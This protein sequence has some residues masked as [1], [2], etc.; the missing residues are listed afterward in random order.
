M[1]ADDT[2]LDG[3]TDLSVGDR[4]RL[5]RGRAGLTQEEAAGLA[6]V[7]VSLWRKWEQGVR[8]IPSF[9]RLV[10]VAQALGV[11]DLR[12]L[13]G[14]PLALTP[15]GQPRHEAVGPLRAAMARHPVLL[16]PAEMTDLD[17]LSRRVNA[18]W[19]A[20]QVASPWR[21]A[22]TG[23]VLPDLVVD[24]EAAL[25][26]GLDS[27]RAAR[28]AGAVY[29]L[30]RAWAKWVG[31]H[32]L[33][34]LAAERTLS[35]AERTDDASLVAAAGWNMA[36][37]LSTRGDAEEARMVAHDALAA[38]AGDFA[39]EQAP[40]ELVSAWGA[41]HLISMV[42]AVRLDDRSGARE[43]LR[44]AGRAA[45]R[46]GDDRND[47]WLAFGPTN[48][49]IHQVSYAVELGQSRT[50]LR[51]DRLLE[52]GRAPSVE[53]RVTHR[54]DVGAA[55]TRLREDVSAVRTLV[56]AERE[57]PEQLYYSPRARGVVRELLTRES[58]DTRGLLRPLASRLGV[59]A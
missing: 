52:V 53:R 24:V 56:D 50:A 54:M 33:A 9:S 42:A 55:H 58:A 31:E 27:R 5:W 16:P 57:S 2:R 20:A 41:L 59:L 21:Y 3:R 43:E 10:D 35:A 14:L 23:A 51:A 18:A 12:H 29:L 44:Q 22:H 37:A 25:R 4:I 45:A 30:A 13:T 47:W 39:T 15:G 49:A 34:M 32:D 7:S 48:V 40:A 28:L 17:R 11:D 36:Q 46:I 26:S 38:V 8:A 1:A 6:G 19:S